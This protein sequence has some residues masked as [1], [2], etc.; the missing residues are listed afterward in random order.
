MKR[1]DEITRLILLWGY[2]TIG[3][4]SDG[5]PFCT[6]SSLSSYLADNMILKSEIENQ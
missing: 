3:D 1:E 5:I 4:L 2:E 6:L